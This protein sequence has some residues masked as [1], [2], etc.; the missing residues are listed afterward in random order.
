MAR[1]ATLDE[2]Y[3]PPT[4]R[5]GDAHAAYDYAYK[6]IQADDRRA[7]YR[8]TIKGLIDG[9]APFGK[10]SPDRTN[11]NFRQA[12]AIINQ[13][14]T[15][16]YDLLTEV[17]LLFEIETTFGQSEERADWG[18]IMSEEFHRL[19]TSWR[20][21]DYVSQFHQFQMLVHGV[22]HCYW[23]D[24]MDWRPD[25]AKVGEVLVDD[26]SPSCIDEVE[27][28]GIRKAYMPTQLMGFIDDP[29]AA[30]AMGWNVDAVKKAVKDAFQGK[31][32]DGSNNWEYFQQ[33]RKNADLYYGNY[34]CDRNW[35][36]HMLVKEYNQKVSHHI[37]RTD[38]ASKD[39]LYTKIDRFNS[40][41]EML[42]PFFYDIGDGTFHSIRGLGAE[43]FPYCEVFNR[44]RCKEVDA[45]VIAASVLLQQKDG[46]S[47]QQSQMLTID[48]LKI[49]PAGLQVLEHQI[50]QNIKATI[51]VRRDMEQGMMN[52]IGS[53]M[54]APGSSNP[55]KGQKQ[56]I[57][58]MQQSAQLGKGNINRYYTSLDQLGYWMFKKASN[59]ALREYHQG[60]KSALEFQARCARRGVPKK[61]F[62]ELDFVRAYRSIGAGSAANALMITNSLME[63]A[64]SLPEQGR[65]ALLRLYI[66][67]LAGT[68]TADMLVGDIQTKDRHTNDESIAA[69]ENNALRQGGQVQISDTQN[70][71]I[72]ARIHI[73]DM[74]AHLKEVDQVAHQKDLDVSDLQPLY[75]HL[76]SGLKHSREHLNRLEGDKIRGNDYKD[77]N[78]Q[79]AEITRMADQCRHNLEQMQED[80]KQKQANQHPPVDEEMLK[81]LNYNH[82]PESVKQQ[83][84]ARAGTPRAQGD[85]SV[86]AQNVHLKE[87]NLR[88]KA[89]HQQTQ[90]AAQ[91]VQ[92]SQQTEKHRSE[93]SNPV[94][95]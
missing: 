25:V 35:T 6:L 10:I 77:L 30:S 2:H 87:E 58:E 71:V 21:W 84:E 48:N 47:V 19:I 57:M 67:R 12:T 23:H 60:S 55:R 72:H 90:T 8:T 89:L 26:L 1:L 41:E 40:M 53:L 64:P 29:V 31:P 92:L 79:W 42:C 24:D 65:Q 18:Q 61:A 56:A 4:S 66:S 76:E 9:N 27:V 5:L 69:L 50:G 62:E 82:V 51:D 74:E 46:Q 16:Y 75:V 39:Y 78:K 86:Q 32:P 85:M 22:G 49:I 7:I 15:P 54:K 11:L 3:K 36:A 45:A 43:I 63:I 68:R 44:L 52:N 38:R 33:K 73:Q 94:N 34:E 14:K 59:P 28:V 17:P 81:N 13:F 37:I 93:M 20:K 91:D 83:L 80:E 70:D 95:K 88:L